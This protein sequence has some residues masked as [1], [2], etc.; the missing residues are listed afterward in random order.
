MKPFLLAFTA[1]LFLFVGCSGDAEKGVEDIDEAKSVEEEIPEI[2]KL[3]YSD[4]IHQFTGLADF[5]FTG[6]QKYDTLILMNGKRFRLNVECEL[7]SSKR[8]IFNEN[9]PEN[10]ILYQ[11]TTVGYQAYYNFSLYD[12][13]K[14]IFRTKLSKEDFKKAYYGLVIES[15]AY[16]P[17]FLHYNK[18]FNA[19]VFE[20][21]FYINES[22][23]ICNALLV[24]GLDGKVKI[25]DHL[26]SS[27]GNSANYSVQ[28]TKDKSSLISRNS[29]YHSDGNSVDFTKNSKSS[30]M[31]TD[32]FDDCL[33][34][35]YDYD[36]KKHP[37]NAYLKDYNGKTL[38]NFEYTGWTGGLGY[39]F[40]RKKV[41]NAYYFIDEVNKQLTR[42]RKENGK[43]NYR[44]LPFSNM[45]DYD[46]VK[47]ASEVEV[48]LTTETAPFVFYIDT[49]SG[50][51]RIFTQE[52]FW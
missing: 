51:I 41:K 35:V 38:L 34:V 1:V 13:T 42:L 28:M 29:I 36:S 16:L 8:I 27:S 22:D 52:I 40:L 19:I 32:V 14:T 24:I 9:Y 5:D 10:H 7:D 4:T 17:Q 21:P 18:S 2:E 37:K 43:W 11:Y 45:E 33:L 20:V 15:G 50:K 47:R 12:G 31:G 3:V 6:K 30:L 23:V 39:S 26:A 44:N 25:V 46:D 48:D 49:V